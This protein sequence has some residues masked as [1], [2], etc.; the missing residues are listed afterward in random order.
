MRGAWAVVSAAGADVFGA[1][2][3]LDDLDRLGRGDIRRTWLEP[4]A[5]GVVLDEIEFVFLA[6]V[7]RNS[8]R[9][10]VPVVVVNDADSDISLVKACDNADDIAGVASR[11]RLD[12][13]VVA[14]PAADRHQ[15]VLEV[16]AVALA[17]RDIGTGMAAE[18]NEGRAVLIRVFAGDFS[19][20]KVI[21]LRR[22][23]DVEDLS[24]LELDDHRDS[25][26]SAGNAVSRR[27]C[28]CR[29]DLKL[30]VRAECADDR[31]I[32]YA[33]AVVT[34]L[35]LIGRNV[36][37]RSQPCC[38]EEQTCVVRIGVV[39]VWVE[40]VGDYRKVRNDVEAQ[41]AR[42]GPVKHTLFL[43]RGHHDGALRRNSDRERGVVVFA[44]HIVVGAEDARFFDL[45]AVFE[46][47]DRLFRALAGDFEKFDRCGFFRVRVRKCDR[48]GILAGCRVVELRRVEFA[49]LVA[50]S[51]EAGAGLAVPVQAGVALR[52]GFDWLGFRCASVSVADVDCA[53]VAAADLCS[54]RAESCGRAGICTCI[55]R[56]S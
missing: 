13:D 10:A 6:G 45:L 48:E 16:V 52:T 30:D 46:V 33:V 9:L 49:S 32:G 44:V 5:V 35:A 47:R 56:R 31:E 53:W 1:G 20:G 36:I 40:L 12:Y 55:G 37:F 34:L 4:V 7:E 50:V 38:R 27:N 26:G 22:V 8:L 17:A 2:H 14:A 54:R 23:F 51:R 18:N 42:R 19:S 11:F 39:V 15:L 25:C 24:H 41:V 43:C 28:G 21:E 3:E 29:R